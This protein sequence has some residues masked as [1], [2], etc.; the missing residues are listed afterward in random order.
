MNLEE[1][2]SVCSGFVNKKIKNISIN[3]I[4][5]DSREVQ[6]NDVFIALK[7]PNYDGHNFISEVIKKKPALIISEINYE[8]KKCLI[9][10]VKDTYQVLLDLARYIRSKYNI[11]LIAIT[12]STGK[13]FTKELISE[14]LN[15][16][17]KVLKS[18]G[19]NNNHIGVPLTFFDLKNDHE[20]I[21]QELGM[22]HVGEIDILSKVC[23]PDMGV[24]TN[25]G[26]SHIG[27]IG[28]LKK[29]FKAKLEILN[30]L[31]GL[32]IV[33]GNDIYLKK[34]PSSVYKVGHKNSEIKAHNIQ[35]DLLQ[36]KFKLQ[37]NELEYDVVLNVLGKHLINNV[38]LAIA[39]GLIYKIDIEDIIEVIKNYQPL[40]GRMNVIKSRDYILIND[41]YNSSYESLIGVID[42]IKNEDI[43]LIIG[44]ILELGKYSSLIHKR[45]GRYLKKL[46][47]AE[48]IFIG[49]ETKVIKN[50]GIHLNSSK[51]IINYLKKKDL[52]NKCILVKGS[53]N[54]KLE[55]V[56]NYLK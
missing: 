15:L 8:T 20:I 50:I 11:P 37:I 1:I 43:I 18:K 40:D 4:R 23:K 48:I 32:L 33:N 30:H 54:L 19:S 44:D 39:V 34:L 9:L 53:R 14:I 26:T 36:T 24:I 45:I 16:K 49:E 47:K 17:Y 5:T 7:G 21:V 6:K 22:N 2:L 27:N 28:S 3:K 52:K 41:C 51:E 25:I 55:K 12:G 46:K 31:N 38:L 35:S 42:L 29:I 56:V 10:K 13:T